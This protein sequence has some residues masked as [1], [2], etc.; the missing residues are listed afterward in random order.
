M[1]F[2]SFFVSFFVI[3]IS[4]CFRSTW[5]QPTGSSFS[6]LSLVIWLGQ[7]CLLSPDLWVRITREVEGH[8][9]SV[10]CFNNTH[11]VCPGVNVKAA[12]LPQ[13]VNPSVKIKHMLYNKCIR[14]NQWTSEPVNQTHMW[15]IFLVRSINVHKKTIT[16]DSYSSSSSLLSLW[17]V[18]AWRWCEKVGGAWL[19]QHPLWFRSSWA[20]GASGWP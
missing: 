16:G 4:I 11:K 13:L 1:S 20:V 19:C 18:I 8:I 2:I 15:L 7:S 6:V 9:I 3:I 14:L 5:T 10:L 12:L 17:P